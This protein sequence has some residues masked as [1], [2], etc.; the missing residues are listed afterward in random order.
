MP[1]HWAAAGLTSHDL[2]VS[3][4][5]EIGIGAHPGAVSEPLLPSNEVEDAGRPVV[6]VKHHLQASN[7]YLFSMLKSSGGGKS[8]ASLEKKV[9][10]S[11][12]L[13]AG[14]TAA[15]QARCCR[16]YFQCTRQCDCDDHGATTPPPHKPPKGIMLSMCYLLTNAVYCLAS[17]RGAGRCRDSPTDCGPE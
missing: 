3:G 1:S 12:L 7:T 5:N 15:V 11:N 13:L 2:D 17:F 4:Q 14:P 9:I 8:T 16:R 10:F 6:A